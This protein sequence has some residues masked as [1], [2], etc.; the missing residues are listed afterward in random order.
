VLSESHPACCLLLD[1]EGVAGTKQSTATDG[2][3]TV[4]HCPDAGKKLF[5][6]WGKNEKFTVAHGVA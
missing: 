3:L 2:N 1:N 6:Q 4:L 5:K